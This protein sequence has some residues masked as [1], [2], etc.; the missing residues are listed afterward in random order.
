MEIVKHNDPIL[1]L[2]P[3]FYA[4][5]N[6]ATTLQSRDP[7]TVVSTNIKAS[8]PRN[9][10]IAPLIAKQELDHPMSFHNVTNR[11]GARVE[12]ASK[13]GYT[14]GKMVQNGFY[15]REAM[16]YIPAS[17][18]VKEKDFLLSV[19]TRLAHDENVFAKEN[20]MYKAN[21]ALLNEMTVAL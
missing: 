14:K 10:F 20:H 6:A 13:I 9:E 15:S 1:G 5:Y 8:Y 2:N 4:G 21:E 18:L 7:F 16:S 3:T 12:F 11:S 17:G 19:D